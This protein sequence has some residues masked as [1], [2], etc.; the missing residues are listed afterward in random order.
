[1]AAL[2][3]DISFRYLKQFILVFTV[4]TFVSVNLLVSTSMK[5]L[6]KMETYLN[7]NNARIVV[8]IFKLP[9]SVDTNEIVLMLVL[10]SKL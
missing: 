1:M 10:I 3:G 8:R 4:I 2:R 5:L 7:P 6:G 9:S